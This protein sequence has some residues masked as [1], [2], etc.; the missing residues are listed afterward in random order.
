MPSADAVR[1]QVETFLQQNEIGSF[2]REDAFAPWFLVQHFRIPP[3]EA[4][5]RSSDS[6]YDGGIDAYHLEQLP[7]DSPRLWMVQAKLSDSDSLVRKGIDDLRRA[8]KVVEEIIA[9]GPTTM[10]DEHRVIRNLRRDLQALSDEQRSTVEIRCLLI[11]LLKDQELWQSK[12]TVQKAVQDFR[13][14]VGDSL[15]AGR[16]TILFRG[17]SG[18]LEGE[19]ISRPASA[20]PMRF[21]GV[22]LHTEDT[23]R[24]LF[25]LCHLADLVDLHEKYRADLFAKNVRMYLALQAKKP[26]SAASHIKKSL[27]SICDGRM[28][29]SQF[30]MTHNGV[31]LSVPRANALGESSIQ[32]EPGLDGVY[33]LNGCQTVYTAWMFYK[34]RLAKKPE[35]SWLQRWDSIRLPMRIIVTRNDERVR[36]V[37]V[38]AN[39]QTEIRPSAFWAHDRVQMDLQLRFERQHV[40]YERQQGAWDQISRLDATKVDEFANGSVNIETLARA[41]AAADRG[42]SLEFA[43]SPNRIFDEESAYRRVFKEKNL[44]SVR[45]LLFLVNTWEA[46]QLALRDISRET[47]KL[48]DLTPSRF[49]FPVFRLLVHW[50]VKR[51]RE[52]VS[53][54]ADRRVSTSPNSDIRRRVRLWLGHHHSGIQQVLSELWYDSEDGYWKDEEA[55]DK[56]QIERAFRR[57]RLDNTFVFEGWDNFD[58]FEEGAVV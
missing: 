8:V 27:E 10:A 19:A 33:V 9:I 37:T 32:L 23:D 58:D 56:E 3:Q 34:E 41:I 24:A 48:N 30:A 20:I 1:K 47:A 6:N 54:F 38:G 36:T 11:H 25:G 42:L 52:A 53:E 14:A 44:P 15:L 31:T 21:E 45:L 40:F 57:L 43:K 22:A 2:R 16:V 4:I 29:S 55:T 26:K 12:P 49:W 7:D 46:T 39:R 13:H 50:I 5:A 28:P 17:P 18:M 35:E 51:N